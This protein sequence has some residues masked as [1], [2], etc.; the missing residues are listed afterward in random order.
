MT[1][2]P[3]RETHRHATRREREREREREKDY[4]SNKC[5]L[6]NKKLLCKSSGEKSFLLSKLQKVEI[7][8]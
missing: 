3:W 2:I 1:S 6:I 4:C 8:L 5:K 7:S